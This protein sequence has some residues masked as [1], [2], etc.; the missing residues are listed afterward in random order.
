MDS[1]IV[2]VSLPSMPVITP[3]GESFLPTDKMIT[4][5]CSCGGRIDFYD[6]SVA[7]KAIN[8]NRVVCPKC[9]KVHKNKE[10]EWLFKNGLTIE[11]PPTMFRE[12]EEDAQ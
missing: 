1:Y 2:N 7:E 11:L 9:F 12:V 8:E 3:Q 6:S 10:Y 5:F 4:F